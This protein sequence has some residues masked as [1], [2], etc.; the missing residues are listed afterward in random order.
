MDIRR[1]KSQGRWKNILFIT[2]QTFSV[3]LKSLKILVSS[4]YLT[5]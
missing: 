4:T 1:G 3:I 2:F 5:L